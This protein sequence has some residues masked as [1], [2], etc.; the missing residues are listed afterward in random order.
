MSVTA[1]AVRSIVKLTCAEAALPAQSLPE[2]SMRWGPSALTSV[3]LTNGT[4]SSR[5]VVAVKCRSRIVTVGATGALMNAPSATPEIATSG[6]CV[7]MTN[8]TLWLV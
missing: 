2:A 6:G 5:L 8:G 4:P 1:G 3:P 7:S